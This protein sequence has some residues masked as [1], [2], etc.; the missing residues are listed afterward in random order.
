[1][2]Q[3]EIRALKLLSA[4]DSLPAAENYLRSY[5]ANILEAANDIV[6]AELNFE[7]RELLDPISQER[8]KNLRHK[9]QLQF[10]NKVSSLPA[11][12]NCAVTIA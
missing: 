11:Q 3:L 9:L 5:K 10:G 2:K 4:P 7:G 8:R 6:K 1:M 12:N